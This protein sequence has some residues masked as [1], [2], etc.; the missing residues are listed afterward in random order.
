MLF[1]S[2][3][4]TKLECLFSTMVEL[5]IHSWRVINEH[6]TDANKKKCSFFCEH[7]LYVRLKGFT[8]GFLRSVVLE[9]FAWRLSLV[10]VSL[11][12]CGLC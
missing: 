5:I 8:R 11:R 6:C 12:G 4:N 9:I 3:Q 10:Q 2:E 1:F 7:E